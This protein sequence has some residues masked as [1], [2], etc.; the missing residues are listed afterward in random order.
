M[1]RVTVKTQRHQHQRKRRR[2]GS[3]D[4]A[5]PHREASAIIICGTN[6]GNPKGFCFARMHRFSAR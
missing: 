2:D 5:P 6:A 3:G 4:G 1:M